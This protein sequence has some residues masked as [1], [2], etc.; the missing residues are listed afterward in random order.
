MAVLGTEAEHQRALFAWANGA[1]RAYPELRWL[2]ASANGMPARSPKSAAMMVA[3]GMRTG[4]PDVCLPVPRG[5]FAGLW[6]ELK[7]PGRHATSPVQR[8]WLSGLAALGYRTEL[9]VG[10]DAARELIVEYLSGGGA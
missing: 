5:G 10:W 1:R 7:R 9:C 2:H 6:I 4:V 3:Q 8:E